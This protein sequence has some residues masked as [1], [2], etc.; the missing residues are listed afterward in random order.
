MPARN[1][2]KTIHLAAQS[3]LRVLPDSGR[4]LVYDDA[5]EDGT[6]KILERIARADRRVGILT[7]RANV[8]VA[9]ALNT[10]I[11]AAETPLIARMDADDISLPWRFR[12]QLSALYRGD[13]DVVFA[14][15]IMFGKK[16]KLV[17][18]QAPFAVSPD[19]SSYE[20]LLVN[21]LPHPT[22]LG[23]RS[24]FARVGGYRD[25][26][27]EDWD[28]WIRMALEGIRLGRVAMPDL[29]YRRHPQQASANKDW[30][31]AHAAQAHDDLCRRLIGVSSSGAFAGLSGPS[32]EP[33][34]LEAAIRLVDTVD[35]VGKSFASFTDRLSMRRTV[36]LA[37]HRLNQVYGAQV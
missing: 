30:R 37:K 19:A 33:F 17:Q 20:L 6:S 21:T 2:E 34:E 26:P 9:T 28:L 13:L 7:S 8:G 29:L 12:H 14:S 4:M 27:A 3:I 22:L 16:R 5:S 32:A 15:I 24:T 10:L 31:S 25:V 18:P 23:R 35:R 1:A 36:W 11:D